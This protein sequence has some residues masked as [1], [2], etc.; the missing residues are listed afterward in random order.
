MKDYVSTGALGDIYYAETT[1]IR[2]RGIP[3]WGVF[4]NK[5]EQ[6]G[7]PLIDIATHS[8]DL[9]ALDDEQLRSR[10][11]HRRKLCKNREIR[12]PR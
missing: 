12:R 6:G 1:A 8:L 7:G 10:K 5:A 4:T 11:R 3:T 2:R 9:T